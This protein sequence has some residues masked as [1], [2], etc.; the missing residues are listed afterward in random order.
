MELF[1]THCHLDVDAFDVD[2]QEVLER[3]HT[4]GVK[5]MVIPGIQA[6]GWHRLLNLCAST[7]GLYPALGMH[8]MF[9]S[10]H[11]PAHIEDL[12]NVVARERP[13]AIGEIGLDFYH[14]AHNREQQLALFEAQLQV[15]VEHELPVVLHVRKAHDQVLSL[16]KKYRVRGGTA[17]AFNG[18]LQQADE[19]IELGFKLGFGGMLSYERSTRLRSLAKALPLEVIVLETDA[20][21]MSGAAHRGS[22]NSPAYLPEYL[23]ALADVREEELAYIAEQTTR[24]AEQVFSIDG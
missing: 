4:E 2:R 24:N 15:A 11:R 13:V 3:C 9:M 12:R 19:Y 7:D 20:P 5:Q 23:R 8:P 6:A 17:H 21:D 1:D 16:L 22:R 18:S 10:S 14:D